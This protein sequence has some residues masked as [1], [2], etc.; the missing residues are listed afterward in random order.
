MSIK[1]MND[2]NDYINFLVG[3]SDGVR[4]NGSTIYH[5]GNFTPSNYLLRSGD[6]MTGLLT[7]TSSAPHSGIRLGNLYLTAINEEL[8]VQNTSAIRFGAD[9]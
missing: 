1:Q 6:S 3:A 2:A 7:T 5:A 9:E 4:V 8:I